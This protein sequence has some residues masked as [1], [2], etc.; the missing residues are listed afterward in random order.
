MFV[1]LLRALNG[2]CRINIVLYRLLFAK[3]LRNF[4]NTVDTQA[5]IFFGINYITRLRNLY[6]LKLENSLF[7]KTSDFLRFIFSRRSDE[8]KYSFYQSIA[9]EVYYKKCFKVFPIDLKI[10]AS[11]TKEIASFIIER[12]MSFEMIDEL[13]EEIIF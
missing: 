5:D 8:R 11:V 10:V 4:R 12:S 7:L 3:L 1:I 6:C 13:R 2:G 9:H